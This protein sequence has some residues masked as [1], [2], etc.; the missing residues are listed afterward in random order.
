MLSLA[1]FRFGFRVVRF[2][3]FHL[4][5]HVPKTAASEAELVPNKSRDSVGEEVKI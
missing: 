1:F 4:H 2:V 3:S 5:P